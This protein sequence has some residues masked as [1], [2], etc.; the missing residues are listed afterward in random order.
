[1]RLLKY[2][3]FLFFNFFGKFNN[4]SVKKNKILDNIDRS[5]VC[6]TVAVIFALLRWWGKERPDKK[7][8]E[9]KTIGHP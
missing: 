1:M 5:S 7:T 3:Y 2:F 8:Q 4:V 9:N 6:L